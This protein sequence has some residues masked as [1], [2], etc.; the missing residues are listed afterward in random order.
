M[1][2]GSLVADLRVD[3][4]HL[5]TATG[6]VRTF[7]HSAED[8]F[9]RGE[10]AA[11][12]FERRMS[13]VSRNVGRKLTSVGR[14]ITTSVTLPLSIAGGAALK[15]SSD[16]ELAFT[17]VS[18]L[19]PITKKE[20]RELRTEIEKLA[21]TKVATATNELFELAAAG[22]RLGIVAKDLARF[23][24]INA[25]LADATV[26]NA[27]EA[28][29]AL[30]RFSN[31][32]KVSIA[33]QERLAS[34]VVHLGNTFAANEREITGYM[35]RLS[36]L[37]A[38]TGATAQEIAGLSAVLPSLGVREER[39]GTAII[40]VASQLQDIV[41]E[42]GT[43][44][45]ALSA[46]TGRTS[47]EFTKIFRGNQTRG[48]VEFLKS[49]RAA[50]TAGV[51]LGYV[52]DK[53]GLT[54]VRVR[55]VI[56]VMTQS[57]DDVERAIRSSNR[58]WR[59]NVALE[60]EVQRFYD[61]ASKQFQLLRNNMRQLVVD[62][63]NELLPTFREFIGMVQNDI[64]PIV[65]RGIRWFSGLEDGTKKLIFYSTA[66][67]ATLG[68]LALGLGLVATA[69]A[70]VTVKG[71]ALTG[72]IVGATVALGGLV[73]YKSK[74]DDFFRD[75][76]EGGTRTSRSVAGDMSRTE[77]AVYS[78][79]RALASASEK[80][81][82]AGSVSFIPDQSVEKIK[83]TNRE[84]DKLA[85]TVV[86]V[87]SEIGHIGP[88]RF[89]PPGEIQTAQRDLDSI[90]GTL[91]QIWHNAERQTQERYGVS[92]ADP[93]RYVRMV[94]GDHVTP[95]AGGNEGWLTKAWRSAG[96]WLLPQ[97]H[98]VPVSK[99]AKMGTVAR[100]FEGMKERQYDSIGNIARH[101]NLS[102]AGAARVVKD[103]DR[104]YSSVFRKDGEIKGNRGGDVE[105]AIMKEIA[106]YVPFNRVRAAGMYSTDYFKGVPS[107]INESGSGRNRV[108]YGMWFPKTQKKVVEDYL[109]AGMQGKAER[110][111]VAKRRHAARLVK[112]DML[113]NM[114]KEEVEKIPGLE[115]YLSQ[116][117]Y[118]NSK[119]LE[120]LDDSTGE[121]F[122]EYRFSDH[123][124]GKDHFNI[125][126]QEWVRY[127]AIDVKS[128]KAVLEIVDRLKKKRGMSGVLPFGLGSGFFSTQPGGQEKPPWWKRLGKRVGNFLVPEAGAVPVGWVDNV[129][130]GIIKSGKAD[131][132]RT[133]G[134]TVSPSTASEMVLGGVLRGKP[135]S[136][137]LN[138]PSI[139]L[140]D[141]GVGW[142]DVSDE[143]LQ[144]SVDWYRWKINE[145]RLPFDAY[146]NV[147]SQRYSEMVV[148]NLTQG[149][150]DASTEQWWR[151]GKDRPAGL[152]EVRR[153]ISRQSVADQL[154]RPRSYDVQRMH[155]SDM[156]RVNR[157]L[158]LSE[159][160]TNPFN[161]MDDLVPIGK[162]GKGWLRHMQRKIYEFD[163]R[164]EGLL[165]N[166]P[167]AQVDDTGIVAQASLAENK[168]LMTEEVFRQVPQHQIDAI[169][170]HEY[171]HFL[172]RASG[173]DPQKMST[174]SRGLEKLRLPGIYGH[175]ALTRVHPIYNPHH[176]D[177][178]LADEW[179]VRLNEGKGDLAPFFMGW[180]NMVNK[181]VAPLAIGT[182]VFGG[183]M[184]WGN[185]DAQAI[186]PKTMRGIASKADEYVRPR[187]KKLDAL[188]DRAESRAMRTGK[189]P[190]QASQERLRREVEKV[191][192][193]KKY[194]FSFLQNHDLRF[195]VEQGY[196][197]RR[198]TDDLYYKNDA[199]IDN[200]R[201]KL[202]TDF[203][204][205]SPSRT[206]RGVL[207][208]KIKLEMVKKEK[209][210][211]DLIGSSHQDKDD[212]MLLVSSQ[213]NKMT[214]RYNDDVWSM[215][216]RTVP[217]GWDHSPDSYWNHA[218]RAGIIPDLGLPIRG[219]E[220][221]LP[222]TGSKLRTTRTGFGAV[223]PIGVAQSRAQ[224]E[225]A[226]I[227]YMAEE[228]FANPLG[229]QTTDLKS[230]EEAALSN[231]KDADNW[232]GQVME[233][234]GVPGLV[235]LGA[236]FNPLIGGPAAIATGAMMYSGGVRYDRR[237]GMGGIDPWFG[238]GY[239][240]QVT[241]D[242]P[243]NADR[244]WGNRAVSGIGGGLRRAWNWAF[245]E[246]HA[247]TYQLSRKAIE[248]GIDK[249]RARRN[250]L[251]SLML[252][253]ENRLNAGGNITQSSAGRLKREVEEIDAL[254]Q[255][256]SL[257]Y[258]MDVTYG[259][260]A[261]PESLI[262]A[263]R[264]AN[265]RVDKLVGHTVRYNRLWDI[266]D[267]LDDRMEA[268]ADRLY[269]EVYDELGHEDKLYMEQIYRGRLNDNEEYRELL[270]KSEEVIEEIARRR[271]DLEGNQ[272]EF[273]ITETRKML[274]VRNW[275]K[276]R[277]KLPR[278]GGTRTGFGVGAGVVGAGAGGLFM[279]GS[280]VAADE[281]YL[282]GGAE[283]LPSITDSFADQPRERLPWWHKPVQSFLQYGKMKRDAYSWIRRKVTP[284]ISDEQVQ[285][286]QGRLTGV[287]VPGSKRYN[288]MVEEFKQV[289]K[290]YELVDKEL[291][292]QGSSLNE[293]MQGPRKVPLLTDRDMRNVRQSALYRTFGW[294]D[295]R[296]ESG[297][298]LGDRRWRHDPL[299]RREYKDRVRADNQ[300]R[301]YNLYGTMKGYRPL[302]EREV[303]GSAYWRHME[304]TSGSSWTKEG[305]EALFG[306]EPKQLG[307]NFTNDFLNGMRNTIAGNFSALFKGEL[308]SASKVFESFLGT[309]RELWAQF[310]ANSIVNSF[311]RAW[312]GSLSKTFG[313]LFGFGGGGNAAG[314]P[315]G[316]GTPPA[317]VGTAASGG[318]VYRGLYQVGE[319]GPEFVVNAKA[320]RQYR[321]ELE[322]MNM[323]QPVAQV[324]RDTGTT[325]VNNY[326]SDITRR[327]AVEI[328]A[329]SRAQS[330]D[331]IRRAQAQITSEHYN[332][333][334]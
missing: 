36:A 6:H 129:I 317:P 74:V 189:L 243:R 333:R 163:Q 290:G 224:Q 91:K 212:L 296:V 135:P 155:P 316:N 141:R 200:V 117:K 308:D 280:A 286:L 327:E 30:A 304:D 306:V 178:L 106:H 210:L 122:G 318:M 42:S 131:E 262:V 118:T 300:E 237:E 38:L 107:A 326:Y 301:Y 66:F 251:Q 252:K 314:P 60:R 320:T 35:T 100:Y 144:D 322:R 37:R 291:K 153:T 177:E 274:N 309:L 52:L 7:G 48:L 238:S 191:N 169:L 198:G 315:T 10:M 230:F 44:L 272:R 247:G 147:G 253:T 193:L 279:G 76:R 151:M 79:D 71:L 175:G 266:K 183:S 236:G 108:I 209:Q 9:R 249:V 241:P 160:L 176:I 305:V 330:S 232:R 261:K 240:S 20:A 136:G 284:S 152:E 126:T 14:A 171:G 226:N 180:Y 113:R 323:G 80:W 324:T 16:A 31:V 78:L 127:P 157:I 148:D 139:R 94:A 86:R 90:L 258:E 265:N 312:G 110:E 201:E 46:L 256:M 61:T 1:D 41:R 137:F 149:W 173:I 185:N 295:P 328:D 281:D 115:T 98:A 234:A 248:F 167:V 82:G 184:L 239:S 95:V 55:Q 134:R 161:Y 112:N 111:V 96:N 250:K 19:L 57:I 65:R 56:A 104:G 146:E 334:L 130:D 97:A 245:P 24:E 62:F 223:V 244:S 332:G 228:T 313:A 154:T 302:S 229:R 218:R 270:K 101:S 87:R 168:I 124:K 72:V 59:E 29:L 102:K 64:V 68:P 331:D 133:A 246:A 170:G 285:E 54:G 2:L 58:A 206:L 27:E 282:F 179:A 214:Q 203:G 207:N 8:S 138:A 268:V 293:F 225:T 174:E 299:Y 255:R 186:S 150:L 77:D 289:S 145:S 298:L 120:I 143:F 43:N 213:F 204:I 125:K 21:T 164:S 181:A 190:T 75:F 12:R 259:G 199:I 123:P 99:L 45:K 271:G 11:T 219:H 294:D 93:V 283:G 84:M 319:Q 307:I 192:L 278:R 109:F 53:L 159:T 165:T 69:L 156:M 211:D 25:K 235:A 329:V 288:E 15:F 83:E 88:V 276:W 264:E 116:A 217:K 166:P 277:G 89:V 63:G 242:I 49:L 50:Q 121:S 103:L 26:L 81:Q 303:E 311:A 220:K 205:D 321:A 13:D 17:T 182:G 194:A 28:G 292:K 51:D 18:K 142:V 267:D 263:Y 216:T 172:N 231:Y 128:K 275:E 47:A 257:Q 215:A 158:S 3:T 273:S 197:S 132:I 32:V 221:Y 208:K 5:R 222:K 33:D 23:T 269:D 233:L 67:T 310:L 114:M 196:Y 119:Y 188:I 254:R 105:M 39:G 85:S 162:D 325:I 287:S 140:A 40:K 4:T 187:S 195:G 227:W 22:A 34:T 73:A 260:V 92:S 297:G 202:F 70:A